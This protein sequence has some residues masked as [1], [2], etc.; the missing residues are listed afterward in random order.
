M[1]SEG[2]G[3][4]GGEGR[5]IHRERLDRDA[6]DRLACVKWLERNDEVSNPFGFKMPK[7]SRICEY[8]TVPVTT[9][10]DDYRL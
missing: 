8:W 7:R 5:G 4:A 6:R 9:I 10:I 2:G 1:H 3:A